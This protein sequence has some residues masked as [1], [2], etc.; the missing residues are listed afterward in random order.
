MKEMTAISEQAI[1][2]MSELVDFIEVDKTYFKAEPEKVYLLQFNVSEKPKVVESKNFKDIYGQPVK[3][4]QFK[5]THINNGKE[6]LWDTSKT[7]ALQIARE[8][9][10][11]KTDIL[12]IV[13]HGNGKTT[14]YDIGSAS[15]VQNS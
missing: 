4:Y 7:V 12:K 6:Q 3:K 8:I 13:R 1:K 15:N 5:I 2:N 14:T 11:S 10:N 9:T